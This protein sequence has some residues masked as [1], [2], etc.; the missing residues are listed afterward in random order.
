MQLRLNGVREDFVQ[1]LDAQLAP[2]RGG[3]TPIRLAYANREAIGEI[4]LG[5]AWRVRASPTLIEQLRAMPGVMGAELEL[6]RAAS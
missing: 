2:H 1:R 4:D 5:E 3:S 6:A